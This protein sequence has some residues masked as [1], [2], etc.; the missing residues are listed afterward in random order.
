M[1]PSEDLNLARGM[2]RY[3][4]DPSREICFEGNNDGTP[5]GF[6]NYRCRIA[7]DI[8][9]ILVKN[10]V[11]DAGALDLLNSS[12]VFLRRFGKHFAN[13]EETHRALKE[14]LVWQ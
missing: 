11:Y 8:D 6:W 12:L 3:G 9:Y 14:H 2:I 5:N 10:P 1:D 4:A 7:D 13:A